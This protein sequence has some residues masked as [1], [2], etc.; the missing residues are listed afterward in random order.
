[1]DSQ[2][3][4][5]H[6][7]FRTA[8]CEQQNN[9]SNDFVVAWSGRQLAR[10]GSGFE[11]GPCWWH[12]QVY[13]SIR[14]QYPKVLR[15]GV[16]AHTHPVFFGKLRSAVC[17]QLSA[18]SCLRSAV[19]VKLLRWAMKWERVVLW[20]WVKNCTTQLCCSVVNRNKQKN[21]AQSS[22]SGTPSTKRCRRSVR[23]S[24]LTKLR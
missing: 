5:T 10:W 4:C 17:V 13:T 19:C 7:K 15:G 14:H 1:M 9:H 23:T 18:F 21:S 11:S 6:A 16:L 3:T 22:T 2:H 12:L 24:P 20:W 8:G